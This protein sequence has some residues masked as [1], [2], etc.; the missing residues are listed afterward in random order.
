MIRL[1]HISHHY[2]KEPVL[3]DISLQIEANSFNIIS[4]ESGSG[5]STL[6]SVIST[7]LTPTKGK[8]F[9]DETQSTQIKN[10]DIFRNRHIG[11]VFQFHYLISHF[12]VYENIALVSHKSRKDAQDVLKKLGILDL[13]NKYPDEISGGQRQRAAIA[14]AIIN[15]PKYIFAD[16]PTGSLDSKNSQIVFGIL[17]ELDAT[18]VV[19]THELGYAQKD[20]TMITLKDGR[21]C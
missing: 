16:E 17:R 12:T 4:G 9:F 21:L 14:R 7:L 20:D 2:A 8:L 18:V 6:L 13:E 10:M 15:Q 19:A 3:H 1:E 5:K 11:F